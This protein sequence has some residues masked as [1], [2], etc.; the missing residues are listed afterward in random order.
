MGSILKGTQ[1]YFSG[2]AMFNRFYEKMS[3]VCD[4]RAR[5]S[6]RQWPL[7]GLMGGGLCRGHF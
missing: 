4:D 6:R 3:L 7:C 5:I 2:N 1:Y